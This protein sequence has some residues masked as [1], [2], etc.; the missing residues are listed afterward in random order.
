MGDQAQVC[1]ILK[2]TD[3]AATIEWYRAVGF[4]L[5]GHTPATGTPTWCELARDQLVVQFLDGETPWPGPPQLT[6]CFY[7]HPASV[8][9]VFAEVRD[10]VEAEWGIETREWGARE[11]T[12]RDPN[13]YY[14]VFT[15]PADR[16]EAD[17]AAGQDRPASL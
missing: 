9:A 10:R 16:V 15:E 6:G 1:A 7:V 4:E 2:T 5:R 13:G 3:M 11:L 17:T 12:L 14:L 8:E